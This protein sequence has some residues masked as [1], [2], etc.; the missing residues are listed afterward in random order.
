MPFGRMKMETTL[1]T[2]PTHML[3]GSSSSLAQLLSTFSS[4]QRLQ[5]EWLSWS[6]LI[7]S[8]I[9]L[10]QTVQKFL[11]C[12]VSSKWWLLYYASSW[13][14]T[15]WH[16]NTQSSTASSI[17]WLLKSSWKF[18]T[19]TSSHW[20]ATSWRRLCITLQSAWELGK[21]S[22]LV[23][24]LSSTSLLDCSTKCSEPSM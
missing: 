9:S 11:M 4:T 16:I 12:L 6:L 21:K 18:P 19:C 2:L 5:T 20:K 3:S 13:T 1:Q 14:F 23:K 22:N 24:D 17:L 8:A 15:C 7:S 10:C